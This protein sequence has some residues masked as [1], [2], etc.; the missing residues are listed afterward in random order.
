MIDRSERDYIT[1]TCIVAADAFTIPLNS[2]RSLSCASTFSCRSLW[3]AAVESA[4][5]AAAAFNAARISSTSPVN[6]LIKVK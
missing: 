6:A 2:A 1:R 4:V 5:E 3:L